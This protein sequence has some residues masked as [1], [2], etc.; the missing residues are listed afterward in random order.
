MGDSARSVLSLAGVIVAQSGEAYSS[1]M[2]MFF[3]QIRAAQEETSMNV[4]L[5]VVAYKREVA[6]LALR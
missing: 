1:R 2:D 4:E 5:N 6:A 3:D